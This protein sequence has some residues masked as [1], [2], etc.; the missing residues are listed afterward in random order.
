MSSAR[1]STRLLAGAFVTIVLLFLFSR[2]AGTLIARYVLRT[3]KAIV[4]DML[5]SIELVSRMS[6]DVDRE[7]MLLDDHIIEAR[8]VPMAAIEQL[9]YDARLDYARAAE[10]YERIPKA[11]DEERAWRALA[12]AVEATRGPSARVLELSRVNRDTDAWRAMPA[13]EARF[14]ESDRHAGALI[15]Q[16]HQRADAALAEV[17]ARQDLSLA[18]STALGLLGAA[19]TAAIG[20]WVTRLVRRREDQLE[21]TAR[22]LEERNRELDAFAGRVAHDLRGPLTTVGL[23][24]SRLPASADDNTRAV[25]QRSVDR[26][27]RLIGDLLALSRVD[28]Q[29]GGRSDPAIV[30][31][32]VR[33]ELAPRIT[34]GHGTI[35]VEVAPAEVR[36]GEGLL[37]QVLANVADNALKYHREDVAPRVEIRG[38]AHGR[39]YDLRVSDN[40]I[41]MSPDDVRHAFEPFYRSPEVREEPGTGLGLSIVKR[42]VEV[43]G[44]TVWVDSRLGRGTTI[45]IHLPLAK[46]EPD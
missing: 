16:S 45:A 35:K 40:G 12:S 41:G 14:V 15:Q 18:I 27:E 10:Q 32:Q 21:H 8:A 28:A 13:A 5:E 23:A 20:F 36:C 1:G 24:A 4:A 26:L 44:G 34:G 17:S 19:F 9:I 6:R 43:S 25:L 7:R 42:I 3:N 38:Q 30:A 31:A 33:E 22:L 37:R 2:L 39:G 46:S 29:V 11:P